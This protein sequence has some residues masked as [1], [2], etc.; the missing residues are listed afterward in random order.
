MTTKKKASKKMDDGTPTKKKVGNHKI[1]PVPEIMEKYNLTLDE[2]QA[3][4]QKALKPDVHIKKDANGDLGIT[5][6]GLMQIGKAIKKRDREAVEKAV[7]AEESAPTIRE[8]EICIHKPPNLQKLY[9]I[10]RVEGLEPKKVVVNADRRFAAGVKA[11]TIIKA[12][13]IAEDLFAHI[14]DGPI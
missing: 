5:L 4:G 13:R 11:G 6:Q 2:F 8:L 10:D 3:I 1:Y 9:A 14:P 12:E 7:M